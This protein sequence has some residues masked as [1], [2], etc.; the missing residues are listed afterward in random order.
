MN[1]KKGSRELNVKQTPVRRVLLGAAAVAVSCALAACGSSS[2]SGSTGTNSTSTTSTTASRT[3]F[4]SASFR[5]CLKQHGVTLPS[6]P[7]GA[8]GAGASGTGT[9]PGAGGPPGGGFFGGGGG[10]R[11]AF[12][13]PKFR[14]AIQ[15]CGGSNFRGNFRGRAGGSRLSHT[16]INNYVACVRKHGYNLPAPN[17]SGKGSIFS[18]KIES[19]AKFQAASRSCAS[20]LRPAGAPPAGTSTTAGA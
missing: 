6:R 5:T 19:N 17:F 7:A 14:A 13:N 16:A 2:P 4:N 11:G 20:L 9:T 8:P 10:G 15:A 1:M 3:G 12:S 18:R